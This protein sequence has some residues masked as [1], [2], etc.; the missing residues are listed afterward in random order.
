MEAVTYRNEDYDDFWSID[1]S[2]EFS[3]IYSFLFDSR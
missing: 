1:A 3:F 2:L